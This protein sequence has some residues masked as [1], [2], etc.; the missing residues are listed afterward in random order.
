MYKVEVFVEKGTDPSGNAQDDAT[1]K[2]EGSPPPV[3]VHESKQV[4]PEAAERE[5]K[6]SVLHRLA[7]EEE[8]DRRHI[9]ARA[10]PMTFE[11]LEKAA[12][13]DGGAV[14]DRCPKCGSKNGHHE[15]NV[16]RLS[17]Q[18]RLCCNCHSARGDG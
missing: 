3:E 2:A 15:K 17:D 8:V 6:E 1:A 18:Q 16:W 7:E 13:Q 14:V 4:E 10:R 9:K 11:E 12:R 5:I